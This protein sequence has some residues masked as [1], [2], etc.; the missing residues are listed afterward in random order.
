MKN[1]RFWRVNFFE[2]SIICRD[3]GGPPAP[4]GWTTGL[5]VD[6]LHIG[7]GFAPPNDTDEVRLEANNIY[8]IRTSYNVF[9]MYCVVI[10][11]H[12]NT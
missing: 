12:N 7:A 8:D 9:G 4:D 6:E 3:L 5:D 2:S 1:P 10:T 11:Q